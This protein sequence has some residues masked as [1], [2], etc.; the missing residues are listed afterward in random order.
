MNGRPT[1]Y[2]SHR[3]FF[4][5]DQYPLS[6]CDLVIHTAVPLQIDQ[7]FVRDIIYKPTDLINVCFYHNFESLVRIN[8]THASAIRVGENIIDERPDIVEP[9]FLTCIF[10]TNG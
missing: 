2:S 4:P 9:K 1:E 10:K 7:P 8:N 3:S 6:R 5:V